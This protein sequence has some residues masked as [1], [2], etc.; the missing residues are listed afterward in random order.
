MTIEPRKTLTLKLKPVVEVVKIVKEEE[1]NL[2]VA[3]TEKP[4]KKKKAVAVDAVKEEEKKGDIA[5]VVKPKKKK[6]KKQFKKKPIVYKGYS[7]T[8]Y[9]LLHKHYPVCFDYYK[10]APFIKNILWDLL[11]EIPKL[12]G[13]DF[14][15]IKVTKNRTLISNFVAHWCGRV[16]YLQACKAGAIRYGLDGVANGIVSEQ[17]AQWVA[18]RL[19]NISKLITLAK[20]QRLEEET[21]L[22]ATVEVVENIEPTEKEK[23]HSLS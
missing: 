21:K 23:N 17:E 16:A 1:N 10:P 11:R 3:L 18:A 15:L 20:K 2:N 4:K 14:L 19:K 6:S 13:D 8:L 22:K 5:A 9:E 7:L 12:A